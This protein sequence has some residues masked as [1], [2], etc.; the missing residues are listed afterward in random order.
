MYKLAVADDELDFRGR[1][2]RILSKI[3]V[4]FELVGSYENGIDTYEGVLQTQPDLL[5]T[6][7][8]MPFMNGIELIQKLKADMPL[9]KVIIVSGFDEF[10]YAKQ[11]IDLGVISYITKPITINELEAILIKAKETL[12]K[13]TEMRT[14]LNLLDEFK[15]KNHQSL[16]ENGLN[17]YLAFN[18]IQTEEYEELK[19]VGVLLDY[20]YLVLCNFDFDS[21]IQSLNS[22]IQLRNY[23]ETEMKEK[24]NVD[25]FERNGRLFSLIKSDSNIDVIVLSYILEKIILMTKKYL[26]KDLSVGVSSLKEYNKNPRSLLDQSRN[27]LQLRT[28]LKGSQ[29]FFYD[30]LEQTKFNK[31]DLKEEI[32][33]I[34]Y[35]LRYQSKKELIKFV[36]DIKRNL[37]NNNVDPSTIP[38]YYTSIFNTALESLNETNEY[39]NSCGDKNYYIEIVNGK[40][41]DDYSDTLFEALSLIF[42]INHNELSKNIDYRFKEIVDFIDQNYKENISLDDIVLKMNL[43][44]SYVSSLFKKYNNI[45]FVKYLTSVRMEKAKDLLQQK[46]YKIINV[47][48]LCG[49][50][51]PFYFSH[52][53]K[54]YVGKSP[55]EYVKTLEVS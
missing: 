46:K 55:K 22:K 11:A 28:V 51:D 34:K 31:V 8:K 37:I 5:I 41:L 2:L 33:K 19:S 9:L 50:D 39:F 26:F 42:E 3:D 52:C 21:E 43:S 45:T 30:N 18:H 14:N 17:Y 7:I 48:M 23:V 27:A 25:V 44:K 40:T 53:F 13:E 36:S 38:Y 32:D 24:F 29:S 20:R 15:E 6:D 12:D 1:I 10:D 54:K 35:T 4:G 47:S 49:Y 16:Y